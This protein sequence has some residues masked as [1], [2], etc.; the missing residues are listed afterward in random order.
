[1]N[2]LCYPILSGAL[3]SMSGFIGQ[4]A[5]V[6]DI[7]GSLL[8]LFQ[9]WGRLLLFCAGVLCLSKVKPV[10][11]KSLVR[12]KSHMA[13]NHFQLIRMLNCLHLLKIY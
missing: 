8:N 13:E 9:P 12:P 2:C 5:A 7:V 3:V 10:L 4:R 11:V 1:M 6:S